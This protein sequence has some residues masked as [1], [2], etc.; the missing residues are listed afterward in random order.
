MPLGQRAFLDYNPITEAAGQR[1]RLYRNVRWG[2]HLEFFLLDTRQYRDPNLAPDR[3]DRP[4]TMLGREQLMWLEEQLAASDATWKLIVSSVPIA[5]PTGF[6]AEN[7]RDG[8]ANY[9]QD[10]GFEYELG[11]I[12]RGLA[13]RGDN[14]LFLATDVHFAQVLRYAPFDHWPGFRLHEAMAG[15]L[16]AGLF[17]NPALDETWR[18]ERLFFFGPERIG[19]V[20]DWTSAKRWLN[21]GVVDIDARGRLR[22]EIRNLDGVAVYG[23]DLQPQ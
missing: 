22:L 16:S 17:P 21:Y 3:P 14:A 12:L 23:L 15:P 5:V 20:T 18:P 1:A 4:K 11:R 19:A 8:W 9:D 6:P 13:E 7:G 10:T 2:R